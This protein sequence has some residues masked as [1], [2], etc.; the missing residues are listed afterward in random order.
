MIE[1]FLLTLKSMQFKRENVAEKVTSHQNLSFTENQQLFHKLCMYGKL[2][3]HTLSYEINTFS[4]TCIETIKLVWK[5]QMQ[6][7]FGF[8]AT[9]KSHHGPT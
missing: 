4:K 1:T 9:I 6:H 7:L 3:G 2:T 5:I 8:N